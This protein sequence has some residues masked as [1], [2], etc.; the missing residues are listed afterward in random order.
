MK[1]IIY[2]ITIGL[3]VGMNSSCS[4]YLDIQPLDK[5]S[6]SVV[7]SDL[8]LAETFVNDIYYSI[9]H[10]FSNIMMASFTDESMY[11]ADFG[12]SN[13]TKSLITPSDYSV[14]DIGFW[15][16]DR[17]SKMTWEWI[18]GNIRATNMFLEQID[19]YEHEDE[20]FKNRLKGEVHFLRAYHYHNLVF[21]YGG[22]PN[23]TKAYTLED[24]LLVPRNSFEESINLI[25]ADCDAAANLLPTEHSGSEIGRATKGAALALKSRVLLWAA[26]DLY[27]DQSWAGGYSNPELIGYTGGGQQ[28]RWQA[29]KDAAKAVMDLDIYDV[30][31]K[32]PS[33]EDS[34]AL[35][36]GNIFLNYETE[37]D[38]FVRH[39]IPTS[40]ENW[41][42]YDPGKFN[43][44]NGYHGWGSN[45]PL[46]QFVDAFEM[47][48]GTPFDWNNPAHAAE[49]Y[50][51]REP[52]FYASILYEGAQWRQRPD[53]VVASDPDGII[54]V[55]FWEQPDGTT[56]PG[57][58]TR[59]GPIED[60]NG[61]HTGYYLKKMMD[62]TKNAQFEPQDYPWRF[63]RYTEIV[64]N[65]A[66]ACIEL[67]ED[68]EAKNY[69]NMIRHRAGMPDIT[70]IGDAL[71]QRYRHERH[72]ELSYEDQRYFD[73]RR[74]MIASQ[75]I[76]NARGVSV[77]YELLP[78]NT[79]SPSPTYTVIEV[80]DRDW[81][82]RFYFM[83]IKLDEM[84]RNDKLIQNPLY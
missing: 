46:G 75:S 66:E 34:I 55:G 64:L 10:G 43:A 65:Y 48:D 42:T 40:T 8:L 1:K 32:N 79:T 67:G 31:M 73:I 59:S 13:I 58:D 6:E 84:N 45:T 15:T 41:D 83:P 20:A 24:E 25:A 22:V 27:N 35:N 77:I 68:G 19:L 21:M 4:D 7:W 51:N 78:D 70:E 11:N 12:T 57:L 44:P 3:V 71:R 62:P 76:Q 80:Q 23:I 52:R 56:I 63:I 37:E 18:Y 82:D 72:I 26:S 50:K 81:K 16:N 54:Q 30:Y 33:P 39:F 47:S 38:I 74:W 9:P 49:P 61:T 17:A 69:I 2:I 36:Y 60:W 29:A 5:Y 28:A 14:Y 53:D